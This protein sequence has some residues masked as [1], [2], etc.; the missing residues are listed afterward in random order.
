MTREPIYSALFTLLSAIDG[1]NTKSRR[2]KIWT[3]VP[4]VNQ[5]AL[6]Q[7]QRKEQVIAV[8]NRPPVYR[9]HVDVYLYA[10]TSDQTQAASS[11]LNPILDAICLALQPRGENQT[12]GGLV[13]YCR[14]DGEIT[15]DEGI[16]GD[17]SVVIIPIEILTT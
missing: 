14:I 15:T 4:T 8:T 17:Q 5:P 6:F 1:L 2:L 16:L 11:I 7:I 10:N 13:Q 3:D 9:L 12:L